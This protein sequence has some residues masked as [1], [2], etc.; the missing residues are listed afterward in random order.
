MCKRGCEY[1]CKHL[2]GG[3][4]TGRSNCLLRGRGPYDRRGRNCGCVSVSVC[5]RA[6][7]CVCVCV[8]VCALLL[9]LS[10]YKSYSYY[11]WV[12]ES[13][14]AARLGGGEWSLPARPSRLAKTPPCRARKRSTQPDQRPI[15]GHAENA[16]SPSAP[17]RARAPSITNP[18]LIAT[19]EALPAMAGPR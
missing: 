16:L 8:C 6:C 10:L 13:N 11:F 19:N 1:S 4:C 7:V 2:C 15:A 18:A 17:P 14:A 5:V 9:K 3:V 12:L